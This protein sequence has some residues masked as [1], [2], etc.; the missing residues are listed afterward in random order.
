[1]I[2]Y[3]DSDSKKNN[4]GNNNLKSHT[5]RNKQSNHDYLNI[6]TPSNLNLINNKIFSKK[7]KNINRKDWDNSKKLLYSLTSDKNKV[8]YSPPKSYSKSK[9]KSFSKSDEDH[10]RSNSENKYSI[11][12]GK[13]EEIRKA[14]KTYKE[15]F[16]KNNNI[17]DSNFIPGK[18][19]YEQ[20][21]KKLPLKQEHHRKIIDTRLEDEVKDATFSPKLNSNS[22]RIFMTSQEKKRNKDNSYVSNENDNTLE[23]SKIKNNSSSITNNNFSSFSNSNLNNLTNQNPKNQIRNKSY[24]KVEERLIDYGK[25]SKSRI[26]RQKTK[27]SIQESNYSFHPKISEKTQIIA[28][29][30]KKERLE[31]ARSFIMNNPKDDLDFGE[32]LANET[33]ENVSNEYEE[34]CNNEKDVTYKNKNWN[35]RKNYNNTENYSSPDS[36]MN[37]EENFSLEK[38]NKYKNKENFSQ[39]SG[40]SK[41]IKIN[42][43]N[44]CNT[45]RTLV[46]NKESENTFFNMRISP[47]KNKYGKKDPNQNKPP[48]NSTRNLNKNIKN[49][50][51]DKNF[52]KGKKISNNSNTINSKSID[53]TSKYVPL[54]KN[55]S[56]KNNCKNNN[57]FPNDSCPNKNLRL[58]KENKYQQEVH[59]SKTPNKQL[60]KIDK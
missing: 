15:K 37:S 7:D 54:N 24:D 22:R 33:D 10:S 2:G 13:E 30:K 35:S 59:I 5:L 57:I 39:N 3:E 38:L 50:S 25:L 45:N 42:S 40:N 1:L 29:I 9:S 58:E 12:P 23:N 46:S 41:K 60:R 53:K 56:K 44:N 14:K 31:K 51:I 20:Y 34:F 21:Q 26:L 8:E 11:D 18:R 49:K 55:L 4:P 19:L 48:Y 27:N 52:S 47:T 43:K 32:N 17:T 28:S 6:N 16:L 36:L